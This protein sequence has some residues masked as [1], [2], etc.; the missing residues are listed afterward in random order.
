MKFSLAIYSAPEQSGQ[1]ELAYDFAQQVLEQ[2]HE[3]YRLF[4]F[5]DGVFNA[6][7]DH[8][9]ISTLPHAWSALITQN[10]LDAVVCVASAQKRNI[11]AKPLDSNTRTDSCHALLPGFCISGLAQLIDAAV[12]SD[13]LLTFAK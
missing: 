2:G 12:H 10:K 13:R 8:E 3:L 7:Q 5:S 9:Q 6:I 4:F 1:A 11:A